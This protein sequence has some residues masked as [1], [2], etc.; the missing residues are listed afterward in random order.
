SRTGASVVAL[1]RSAGEFMT[2]PPPDTRLEPG[3]VIIVLGT[4]EQLSKVEKT[5]G[6]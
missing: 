4:R 6:H 2:A 5:V 1:S 3:N